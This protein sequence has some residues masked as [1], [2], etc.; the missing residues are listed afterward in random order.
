[1]NNNKL[2]K[3]R[4]QGEFCPNPDIEKLGRAILGIV[5][6]LEKH[7]KGGHEKI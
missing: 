4:V 6:S 3:V 7:Q 2:N 1:M 5:M